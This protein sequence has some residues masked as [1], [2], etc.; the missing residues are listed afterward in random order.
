[1]VKLSNQSFNV[2][3]AEKTS[4]FYDMLHI[5]YEKLGIFS[6][7]NPYVTSYGLLRDRIT[8]LNLDKTIRNGVVLDAGCGAW[9]KGVRILH[10]FQPSHIEAVDF[11]ERS[12]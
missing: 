11:N 5:H 4:Q 9:Q 6:E 10:Q 1:M 8:Q 2:R 12:L 3:D 7:D